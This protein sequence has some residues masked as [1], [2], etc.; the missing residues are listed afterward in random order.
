MR[1]LP[2]FDELGD[3][4][5]QQVCLNGHQITPFCVRSP[6]SRQAFCGSCGERTIF[7]CEEC[8]AYLRGANW[9][10]EAAELFYQPP[11]PSAFCIEC[12]KPHPWTRKKM[13][14]ALELANQVGK[15]DRVEM[16]ELTES[17][18][19]LASDTP[20][21]GLAVVRWKKFIGK[22]GGTIGPFIQKLITDIATEAVKRSMGL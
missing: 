22:A 7:S 8:G 20:Q 12:G 4:D 15:V 2:R 17:L 11:S 6:A 5:I 16:E 9:K 3:F 10:A 1:S 19:N 21:S 14:A 18:P 13:N